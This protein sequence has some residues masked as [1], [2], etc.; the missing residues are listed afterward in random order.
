MAEIVKAIYIII[1]GTNAV[2]Y[3]EVNL[4]NAKSGKEKM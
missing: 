4:V 2:N 1:I 3:T